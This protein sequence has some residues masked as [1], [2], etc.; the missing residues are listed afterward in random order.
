M[1]GMDNLLIHA[2]LQ[3]C[4]ERDFSVQGS[5]PGLSLSNGFNV[6]GPKR[7]EMLSLEL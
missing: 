6:Q 3:R 4:V 1:V 7:V 5:K 2:A